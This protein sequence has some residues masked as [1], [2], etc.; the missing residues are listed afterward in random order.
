MRVISL[1]KLELIFTATWILCRIVAAV[2]NRKVDIK[3]ELLLLLMYVNLAVIIRFVYYPWD[4]LADLVVRYRFVEGPKINLIP[5]VHILDF[6]QG[7][8][9]FVNIAGNLLMFVPTG[10]I[11]PILF[12]KFDSFR[13]TVLTGF[14]LSLT[15]EWT[16][17]F[18]PDRVTDIDDLIV[19]TLGAAL[20][21]AVY[22]TVKRCR[23]KETSNRT[24]SK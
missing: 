17:L 18:I 10:I 3:R 21:F 24:V 7:S 20:G 9:A 22:Y 2:V 13:M 14:L 19:N 12:K 23:R 6:R 16:Q 15:I 4:T 11:V 5:F 8:A 1:W